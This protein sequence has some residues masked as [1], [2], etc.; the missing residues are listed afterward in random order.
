MNTMTEFLEHPQLAARGRWRPVD[1][2]AGPIEAL[3]PPIGFD[4]VVPRMDPIPA[5]GAHT[6]AIL[7]ELGYADD[8][9]AGWRRRGL[10]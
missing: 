8:V 2:P 10:V 4:E 5:L 6:D 3:L 9:V 1:S 7:R